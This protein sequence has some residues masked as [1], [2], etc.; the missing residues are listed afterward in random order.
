M[1]LKEP[2]PEGDVVEKFQGSY[3]EVGAEK[4]TKKEEEASLLEVL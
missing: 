3:E 1:Q 4:S 2:T